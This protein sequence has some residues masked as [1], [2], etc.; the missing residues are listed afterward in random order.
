M[1]LKDFVNIGGGDGPAVLR[2]CGSEELL[3]IVGVIG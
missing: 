3:A 1:D 2:G